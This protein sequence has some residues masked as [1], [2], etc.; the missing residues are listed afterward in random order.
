MGEAAAYRAAAAQFAVADPGQR[1][2]EQ[3]HR[4][5]G[6]VLLDLALP[7]GRAGVHAVFR[8]R[9]LVQAGHRVDVDEDGGAAQP[10]RENRDQRL[11]SGQHLAVVT[12]AGQLG[13]GVGCRGRADVGE[14]RGLHLT[15]YLPRKAGLRFCV[16]ADTPSAK[17]ELDRSIAYAFRSSSIPVYS[18][19]SAPRSRTSLAVRRASGE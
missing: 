6:P 16:K 1:Q 7:D 2:G 15:G 17:S 5:R 19:P 12:G 11:A 8:H 9:Q 3:R 14:R 13:D 4:D 10:H 18:G